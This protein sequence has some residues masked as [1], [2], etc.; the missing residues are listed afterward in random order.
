MPLITA[1]AAL[2]KQIL[3]ETYPVWGEGLSR[4][5]YGQWNEAQWRTDWG[6]AALRRVALVEDER[7]LSSAKRYDLQA[8][9]GQE[10]VP[11]LG[12]GAVFTP[13]AFRGRGH[14]RAIVDAMIADAA[15][16]GCRYAVLFS[17][18]GTAFYEALGFTAMPRTLLTMEVV[19][20]PRAGAPATLV[21]AGEPADL[22][23]LAEI[24]M[25]YAAG[26]SFA[27]DR[28]A[29]LLAFSLVRKRLLAGLGP[30]GLRQV[31]FFVSEEAHQPVAYVLVT[32]GPAGAV[33]A[34][35]G[36]RDPSGARIGAMLQ[37]LSAREPSQPA[38]QLTGWLPENPRPPQ[39]RV[40]AERPASEIMMVR[41]IAAD[42]ALPD[43]RGIVY[44][45]SDVF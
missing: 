22:P 44:W 40:V 21:R 39:L 31:E 34:E 3:D 15:A 42:A 35:C 5:A 10:T 23:V 19:R 11:V 27:L 25:H 12:I 37:V 41:A 45:Q 38:L 14:A 36:D 17:D 9:V 29:G 7:L 43:P 4:A 6:R 33:L 18:I 26:A 30:E 1:G 2:R 8:I 28:S 16:R 24:S 13:S 20:K 32:R